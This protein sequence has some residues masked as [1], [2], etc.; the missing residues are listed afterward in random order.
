LLCIINTFARVQIPREP[1]LLAVRIG[2]SSDFSPI[3]RGAFPVM[4]Q[5]DVATSGM[6]PS[7]VFWGVTAAGT[8]QDFH[9]IPF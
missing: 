5:H 9:L 1:R 7:D 4:M 3:A 2:R 8:V 6:M